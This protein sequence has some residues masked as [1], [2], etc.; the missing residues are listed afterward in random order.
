MTG[1]RLIIFDMDGTLIDGQDFIV[2]AMQIAFTREGL[3]LPDRET[4]LSIVGLSLPEAMRAL[5]SD[6]CEQRAR[7]LVAEYKRSF[8][9]LRQARGG[10]EN[11]TLYPGARDALESICRQAA[12]V[13]GVATGKSRRGLDITL[14]A[15]GLRPYFATCQT[16]DTHPSKPH[17]SMVLEAL[18]ETGIEAANAVMVGDT[19][20]DITMGRK[21]GV[22]TI[23]VSW[24]YHPVARLRD[25]GAHMIASSFPELLDALQIGTGR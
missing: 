9:A 5:V 1:R 3:E 15:H 22:R 25:A 10:G 24:G 6:I 4:I 16:A 8:K 13:M 21:A 18:L 2:E 19:E 17:P 20:F 12:T 7:S 23:G 14:D 11:A